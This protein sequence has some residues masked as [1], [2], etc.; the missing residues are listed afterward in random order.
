MT[1]LV[2]LP[3]VVSTVGIGRDHEK[4]LYY[5]ITGVYKQKPAN[6]IH[7]K[8]GSIERLNLFKGVCRLSG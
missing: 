7:I 6:L 4:K 5:N 1:L 2:Q 8:E 3:M